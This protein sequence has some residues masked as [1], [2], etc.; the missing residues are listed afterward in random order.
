MKLSQVDENVLTTL[1]GKEVVDKL[2]GALKSDDGELS[3][4]AKLKGR[5]ITDED[6][7]TLKENSVQQGKE[8]GSKELAKELGLTLDAGE[9]DP[10]KIAEKLK[11]SITT[12][13]EEK[14][15]NQQPGEREKELETKLKESTNK[16]DALFETHG[17]TLKTV[18]EKDELYR[19]LETK[20]KVKERNNTILKSFP[21]KM[22]QDKNDALI[23]INSTF[24]FDELDG[25][26][27]IKRDGEIIRNGAGVPEVYDNIIKSFVEE[28][29]WVKASGMGGGDRTQSGLKKGLTPEQAEKAIIE[30]G[31]DAGSPEGIKMFN[32]MIQKVE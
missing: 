31:K 4:G 18:T 21:E 19:G 16:Y 32:E 29:K 8:I 12:T 15:K 11:N 9:K 13:L 24:V 25:K 26:S 30:S 28:K 1:F 6:E 5:V 10:V 2:S 20:I 17:N 7:R 23:I 22:S 3:L 14:Y 27:V